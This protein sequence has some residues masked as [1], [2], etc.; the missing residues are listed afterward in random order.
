VIDALAKDL[1]AFVEEDMPQ[2]PFVREK[3]TKERTAAR[4][5]I[6]QYF[7]RYPNE[8]FQTELESWRL[9]QSQNFEFTMK[10]LRE[11]VT[12]E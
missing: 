5:A 6:R 9:L 4:R 12:R 7:K 1:P 2:D 8:Q 3:F 11:P 10:R